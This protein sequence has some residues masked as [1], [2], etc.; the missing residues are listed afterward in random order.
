[1]DGFGRYLLDGWSIYRDEPHFDAGLVLLQEMM[2]G[3]QYGRDVTVLCRQ[4]QDLLLGEPDCALQ[5]PEEVSDACV[6]I[7]KLL[8]H[9]HNGRR[10]YLTVPE[11]VK[12]LS[13]AYFFL[14]QAVALRQGC[15]WLRSTL[16]FQVVS[17]IRTLRAQ[18][19]LD[20]VKERLMGLFLILMDFLDELT[21]E[22][23]TSTNLLPPAEHDPSDGLRSHWIYKQFVI[24]AQSA[25]G[26]YRR[27]LERAW[28]RMTSAQRHS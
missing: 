5:T 25:P 23:L 20:A 19:D 6:N 9:W 18:A 11:G 4:L 22:Y 3:N 26:Q 17:H 28:E 13:I 21:P 12:A 14:T 8:F 7:C 15:N 10:Q 27:A 1:M 16:S 2:N 24:A